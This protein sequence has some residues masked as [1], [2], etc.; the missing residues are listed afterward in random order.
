MHTNKLNFAIVG[1]GSIAERHAVQIIANGGKL[2][3]CCDIL[4]EKASEFGERHNMDFYLSMDEMLKDDQIE[5]VSICTPNGL[6][7]SHTLLALNASKHV[8]CEKPMALC[9][10]D[11]KKMIATAMSN[12]K[13]LFMV[14]QNRFN[15]PVVEL[16]KI[17]EQDFLGKISNIHLSCFWNRNFDYYKNSMWKGTRKLDGGILYTQFSH[18]IDILLWLFG[19]V[20]TVNAIVENFNHPAI[21][22]E[23]AG[24]VMLRFKNNILCTINYS[25]N[26]FEKNFEG[27]LTVIGEKGIIKIGGQYLNKLEC[28]NICNYTPS[29]LDKGSEENNYGQY[30]G[31]MSNHHLVYENIMKVFNNEA[32][33]ATTGL[34]G[35]KTVELIQK[36]YKN[37]VWN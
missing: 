6:H 22:I 37:A 36:I 7:A 28:C 20:E 19:E 30:T 3:A 15:P 13:K 29:I 25:V 35:M 33:I 24:V 5:V 11:C 8:V 21:E 27:S 17:I 14:M 18:F 10:E 16:K 32:V 12:N 1:C 2:I 4:A 31:S 23:D 9:V 26:A 34:E